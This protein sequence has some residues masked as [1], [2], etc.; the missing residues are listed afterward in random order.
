MVGRV[1]GGHEVAGSIPVIPTR[2]F[3]EDSECIGSLISSSSGGQHLTPHPSLI[4]RAGTKRIRVKDKSITRQDVIDVLTNPDSITDR[5]GTPVQPKEFDPKKIVFA[6][7]D[8]LDQYA[9]LADEIVEHALESDCFMISDQ[10]ALS[11][12]SPETRR[13][14]RAYI[15]EKFS[16]DIGELDLLTEICAYLTSDGCE[17][18]RI[19]GCEACH[20]TKCSPSSPG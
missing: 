13:R 18:H 6:G 19:S 4:S 12:F 9:G 2:T 8:Q 10:S 3:A 20:C 1:S 7:R 11:D 14:A 17:C 5:W 16:R 15:K